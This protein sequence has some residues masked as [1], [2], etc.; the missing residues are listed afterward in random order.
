MTE[1]Y[2]ES[3]TQF[4]RRQYVVCIFRM[5]NRQARISVVDDHRQ[6][7]ASSLNIDLESIE[8]WGLWSLVSFNAGK[9]QLCS[10][11]NKRSDSPS[12]IYFGA[13]NVLNSITD[14]SLL[15]V[16]LSDS[17]LWNNHIRYV[18]LGAARRLG[19]LRR[20]SRYLSLS[21]NRI[22]IYKAFIRPLLEFNSHLCQVDLFYLKT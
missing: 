6:R 12:A 7:I 4:R 5:Y 9:T 3:D 11:S 14:L 8:S 13:N 19:F 15:G 21:H 16:N 17:L 10:F 1:I 18:N 2:C 22:L 20:C